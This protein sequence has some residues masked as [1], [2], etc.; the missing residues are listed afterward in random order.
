MT[1]D[2]KLQ[3]VLVFL[4]FFVVSQS[5]Q[6]DA[7]IGQD[8]G[9]PKNC[10]C[11]NSLPSKLKIDCKYGI[12]QDTVVFRKII[13]DLLGIE[14]AKNLSFLAIRNSP[15]IDVPKSVCMWTLLTELH[16][17]HKSTTD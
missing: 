3:T 7:V 5:E 17:N 15:L 16:L 11:Q 1:S 13:D 14:A 6:I 2:W 10:S 4:A 9:C 12:I 8:A